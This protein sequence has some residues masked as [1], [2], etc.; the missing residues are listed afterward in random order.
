M[1]RGTVQVK[2]KAFRVTMDLE[3]GWCGGNLQKRCRRAFSQ[4]QGVSGKMSSD[5]GWGNVGP[6]E[7]CIVRVG[8]F[9]L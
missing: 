1:V 8:H 5:S 7:L 9:L 4:R 3:D 6:S 2:K